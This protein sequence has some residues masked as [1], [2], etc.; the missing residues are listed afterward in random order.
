[1]CAL[2]GNFDSLVNFI[3][4]VFMSNKYNNHIL[5]QGVGDGSKSKQDDQSNTVNAKD[6]KEVTLAA[7]PAPSTKNAVMYGAE[8]V[9]MSRSWENFSTHIKLNTVPNAAS[10][11]TLSIDD[12]SV[13][14]HS[15]SNM[16]L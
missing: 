13:Q 2:I 9:S 15:L 1:M 5:M 16:K 12:S 11:L 6:K 10:L 3:V 4:M 14:R 8:A 7:Q